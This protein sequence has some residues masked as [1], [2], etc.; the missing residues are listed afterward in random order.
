MIKKNIS[1]I[2][3]LLVPSQFNF[4]L[5]SNCNSVPKLGVI[6]LHS[7]LNIIHFCN[8]KLRCQT[9]GLLTLGSRQIQSFTIHHLI[10]NL[11]KFSFPSPSLYWYSLFI[12]SQSPVPSPLPKNHLLQPFPSIYSSPPLLISSVMKGERTRN[13]PRVLTLEGGCTKRAAAMTPSLMLPWSADGSTNTDT[14]SRVEDAQ[15][16]Q[17]PSYT[18]ASHTHPFLP[19]SSVTSQ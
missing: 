5:E 15:G 16:A 7:T 6:I 17:V 18:S 14:A 12:I 4:N 1:K 11:F 8:I 13:Q 10:T 19:N 9:T 2:F 3:P